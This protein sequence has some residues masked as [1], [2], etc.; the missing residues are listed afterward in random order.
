MC[1]G[2][3]ISL[4]HWVFGGVGVRAC[5]LACLFEFVGDYGSCAGREVLLEEKWGAGELRL[6]FCG[7]SRLLSFPFRVH[8]GHTR[9]GTP[10]FWI[11]SSV[12]SL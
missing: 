10:P 6:K 4:G 1:E 3:G 5:L 9:S 12:T 2:F 7:F 8:F 11:L